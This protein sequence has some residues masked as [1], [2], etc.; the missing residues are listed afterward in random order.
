MD[1][2]NETPRTVITEITVLV[3]LFHFKEE[4]SWG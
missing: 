4:E 3:L 1:T 2:A